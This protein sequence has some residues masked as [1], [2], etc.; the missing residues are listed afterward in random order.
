MEMILHLDMKTKHQQH[1]SVSALGASTYCLCCICLCLFECQILL[2][3]PKY[4]F[5]SLTIEGTATSFP[6]K[7]K[8]AVSS[9]KYESST[10]RKS[11]VS[12]SDSDLDSL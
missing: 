5:I 2:I 11:K 12:F 7:V 1:M 8:S 3:N 9:V 10:L 6:F 4:N